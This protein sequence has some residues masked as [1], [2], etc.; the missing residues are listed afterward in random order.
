MQQS[1]L[2][3]SNKKTLK[4]VGAIAAII[5]L[6]LVARKA[7]SSN[8][9]SPT[10]QNS[11]STTSESA[12]IK[13]IELDSNLQIAIDD[14]ENISFKIESAELKN[15]IILKGQ[16]ARAVEGKNFLVL[17]IK[18]S[19]PAKQRIKLDTRD[20]VRLTIMDS[21]DRLAP[22]IH[23]DPVEIQPISDQYTRLGF[24][25]PSDKKQFKLFVGEISEEKTE[26]D[27]NLE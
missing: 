21:E 26:V 12:A 16:K 4:L 27:L 22:S 18:L 15:E 2:S 6:S 11:T 10:N 5:L 8:S 3:L 19:N 14:K 20:Y 23:N 24:S 13:K 1:T 25:V 7:F 9:S 17:N